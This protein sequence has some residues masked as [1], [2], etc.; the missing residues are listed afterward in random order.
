LVLLIVAAFLRIDFYF[1]LAYLLFLLYVLSRGWIGRGMRGLRIERRYTGRAFAGDEVTGRVSVHNTG[2]LPLPWLQMHESL[3]VELTAPPF[4]REVFSLGAGEQ[5]FFEYTLY[6][7]K[8]GV[9]KLGPLQ[10]QAGD[11]LGLEPPQAAEVAAEPLM[12]YPKVV[13]LARLGLPTRSP[14]AALPDPTPLFEDPARVVGVRDYERGDSPRRIHWTATASAGRLLVKQ[15]QAAIARDTV[16]CLD[17]NKEAYDLRRRV[18][19]SELAIVAA[20]SLAH[21]ISVQERL[22]VGLAAE[23][24]DA[25]TN[26]LRHFYL[27]A[28]RERG[29]LI[30]VLEALARVQLAAG[31][32][33]AALLRQVRPRLAWG[34][35]LVAIT[36]RADEALFEALAA[37]RHAGWAVALVLAQ[38]GAVPAALQGRA[39]L[40]GVPLREVWREGDLEQWP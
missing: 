35:T 38:P 1:T 25:L 5:R 12:V 14:L 17:L 3:P 13:H 29:H 15:Y 9:Y 26:E 40:L 4:H 18:E 23:G 31:P 34:T 16:L 39:A 8:R 22:A 36:G 32:P 27:P 6:C 28:R 21:H 33:L 10:A 37:L 20:A 24:L 7:R 19:A 30:S 11:V 2:R